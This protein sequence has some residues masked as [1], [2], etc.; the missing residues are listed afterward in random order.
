MKNGEIGK[1]PIAKWPR[2]S[3]TDWSQKNARPVC[4]GKMKKQQRRIGDGYRKKKRMPSKGSGEGP[5][6]SARGRARDKTTR[7]E[8]GMA[9]KKWHQPPRNRTVEVARQ[10]AQIKDEQ[11]AAPLKEV[12]NTKEKGKVA[13]W[14][15]LLGLRVALQ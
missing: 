4:F 12:C 1:R 6:T 14:G 9:G 15:C 8:E 7:L 5:S 2:W 13:A 11:R 10:A 3:G